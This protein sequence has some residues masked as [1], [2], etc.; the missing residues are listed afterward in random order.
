M[1]TVSPYLTFNGNSEE[2]FHFYQSVFGGEIPYMGRFKEMPKSDEFSIPESQ[3]D[4]IMH[5]SLQV[6]KDTVLMG[7]DSCDSCESFGPPIIV[8]IIKM[9][10]EKTFWGSFFGMLT[11]KF[12]I[13]WMVSCKLEANKSFEEEN[14]A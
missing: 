9:V 14:Q 3:G 2:A 10:P 13:Q 7:S 12:G 6:N 8:G 11:D 4:K 5:A 1:T